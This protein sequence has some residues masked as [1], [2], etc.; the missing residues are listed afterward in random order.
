MNAIIFLNFL[1][2]FDVGDL[3]GSFP[4]S[5]SMKLLDSRLIN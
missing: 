1:K 4:T 5:H 2:F 3:D